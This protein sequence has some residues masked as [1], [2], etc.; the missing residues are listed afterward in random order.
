MWAMMQKF[1]MFFIVGA[2]IGKKLLAKA[3]SVKD[4]R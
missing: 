1:L 4:Y 2:K 3:E